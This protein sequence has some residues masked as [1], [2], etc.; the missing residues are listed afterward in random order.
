MSKSTKHPWDKWFSKDKFVLT[1]G[2]HFHCMTHSMVVQIRTVASSR[3]LSTVIQSDGDK[4]T[5][6]VRRADRHAG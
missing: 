6:F 5:V 3:G 1:R 2:R 4:I